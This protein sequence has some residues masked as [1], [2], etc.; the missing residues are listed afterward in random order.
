[1]VGTNKLLIQLKVFGMTLDSFLTFNMHVASII[2]TCNFHICALMHIILFL[3]LDSTKSVVLTIII[4][5]G[6]ATWFT[7]G[8]AIRIAHYDIIDDVITQNL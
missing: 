3:S 8:G 6:Y 4:T 2:R 1:M 5:S 7:A